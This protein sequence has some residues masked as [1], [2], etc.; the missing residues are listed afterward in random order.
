MF[1]PYKKGITTTISI[2]SRGLTPN[3]IKPTSSRG[4]TRNRRKPTSSRGFTRNEKKPTSSR[5]LTWNK[6]KLVSSRGFTRN[7]K[8]K[9]I[10][11]FGLAL[12]SVSW[13][14]FSIRSWNSRDGE[15]RICSLLSRVSGYCLDHEV[16]GSCEFKR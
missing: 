2:S 7:K 5:G 9:V 3:K 10:A 16:G 4:L 8:T 15:S 11:A 12:S 13:P 6:K 1:Y 14:L